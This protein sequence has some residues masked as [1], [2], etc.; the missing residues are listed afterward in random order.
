[1]VLVVQVVQV[2]EQLDKAQMKMKD[3]V[4]LLVE[5]LHSQLVLPMVV[6]MGQV[7]QVVLQDLP[8]AVMAVGM[9]LLTYTVPIQITLLE[10]AMDLHNLVVLR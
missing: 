1:L 4:E 10:V 5:T 6:V 2:L 7:G 3:K 9:G 8:M